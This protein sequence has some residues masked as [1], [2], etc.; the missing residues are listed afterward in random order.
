MSTMESRANSLMRVCRTANGLRPMPASG[1][2][3]I[4][5]EKIRWAWSKFL[6]WSGEIQRALREVREFE[7]ALGVGPRASNR[8]SPGKKTGLPAFVIRPIRRRAADRTIIASA[9][10]QDRHPTK[11]AS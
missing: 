3:Q 6:D 11:A 9:R 4:R 8:K 10:A 2:W 5:F 7:Q 1:R